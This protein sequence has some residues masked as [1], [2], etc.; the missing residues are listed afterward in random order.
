MMHEVNELY[1]ING[2]KFY[3]EDYLDKYNVPKAPKYHTSGGWEIARYFSTNTDHANVYTA[4]G[5][6]VVYVYGEKTWFDTKEERDEYRAKRNAERTA[7]T[8]R[9]KILKAV[10]D[11]VN[12]KLKSMSDEELTA[13]LEKLGA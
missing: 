9:N 8:K 7:L 5:K 4:N 10:T 2:A 6:I 11:K 1:K 12:E 13:L 3:T